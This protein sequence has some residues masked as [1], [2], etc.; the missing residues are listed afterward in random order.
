MSRGQRNRILASR[1][2]VLI[3]L[4][5]AIF[6]IMVVTTT[7]EGDAAP[8]LYLETADIVPET[9]QP[10]KDS[11]STVDVTVHNGGDSNATGFYVKLRDLTASKDLGTM[12]PYNLTANSSIE[13][14]F[15]WDLTGATGGKHT[16][17]ASA[18]SGSDITESNETDNTA[19]LDVTVNLPPVASAASNLGFANTGLEIGFSAAGSSDPDGIISNYLWYFGDGDTEEG[20]NVSHAYTDG[21]P[22]PGKT[23][24]ITLV[25][26]DEDGGLASKTI[27][28]RIY[29][30]LPT[31]IA[32]DVTIVTMTPTSI[33]GA[34]STD[35]DGKVTK[36]RWTLHN[37]TVLWGSTIV[38]SY[39][40]DGWYRIDLLV[41][42]DD[43][44]SDD[45]YINVTV[46]NQ[47]PSIDLRANRTLVSKGD[48]IRFD[49]S[50]SEDVDGTIT[51]YTWIFGDST[52][53]T[54]SV[55]DHS[56]SE[57]G[58]YNI[59]LVLVD[60]DGAISYS[61]IRVIVG[62][63]AP[64]AVA[65]ASIGYVL[66]YEDVEFNASSSS[67]VDDNMAT[68]AWDF[69]D[70]FSTMGKL[71]VHNFTDDGTYV[72]TL[73]L[74]DTAGAFATSTVTIVVGNRAPVAIFNDLTVMTH[75]PVW[76]NGSMCQDKDGYIASYLW[77][78]GEGLVYSTANASH[79]W[80]SPGIYTVLLSIWDDD[81]TKN[82]TTFD[83]TVLNQ[84]PIAVMVAD[85]VETTLA[86]PVYFNGTGSR[87][88]DGEITNWTWTF[89]DG[90][91][92]YGEEVNHTYST[93]GTYFA[94]LTVRDTSGGI[95][96]TGL[97]ISVRNQPPLVSVYINPLVTYTGDI[98]I[99][100]GSNSSD[101]ENQIAEYYW[102]FGDGE[103]ATG[104]IVTH[105]YQDDS[106]YTARLT[107]IDQD[108]TTSF[109]EVI[110][111]V[112][113]R[114]PIPKA[115]A[116][117]ATAKTL[118]SMTFKGTMSEDPDGRVLW[119]HWDFGDGATGFGDIVD[120]AYSDDGTYTVTLT[121]TDDDGAEASHSV[122]VEVTNRA[123]FAMAG[124]GQTTQT[125]IPVRLD[126]RQSYDLDGDVVK[127]LWDFGDETT[128]T[129]PVV[130][131]SF[132]T[133][134]TFL[135]EL[136]VTDDD[137]DTSTS[138]LTVIVQN[139]QPVAKFTGNTRIL[140]GQT[141]E[142]DGSDSYDLDGLIA[143]ADYKWDM[144]DGTS[145]VGILVQYQ[146]DSVGTY[147]VILTV[148]DDG[149]LTST[150]TRMVEVL[151]RMPSAQISASQRVLS[152]GDSL[153]LDGSGS[154][155]PDG[156][157]KD[158]TWI[159]GDGSVAYGRQVSYIYGDDGIYMVVLTV[160]DDL[161]GTDSTSVFIQ[162]EN[163]PPMPAI[164]GPDTVQTL[165]SVEFTAE[166]TLD[167]D[168]RVEGHFWDFGDGNSG[169][170]WNVSHEYITSGIYTVSLIVLDDDGRSAI[171]NVSI[172][173][174]N[175]PPIV[176]AEAPL[177]ATQ[178]TTVNFNATRSYDPDG[179]ITEWQWDFG[180]DRTGEGRDTYHRYIEV[181]T[182][183]WVLTVVDDSGAIKEVSGSI[184]IKDPPFD[185]GGGPGP[186]NGDNTDESPGPGAIVAVA[187]LTLA[188]I[189]ITVRRKRQQA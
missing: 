3:L 126:G 155:D 61:T 68:Y 122:Q 7:Q 42:D 23:Y 71:V 20:Y 72:V 34:S 63:T 14:G 84:A 88:M 104:P 16:L 119:F 100:N 62:N 82:H 185:P 87:D 56:F 141:L 154:M 48:S 50:G 89:G 32:S 179:L 15:T 44:E 43:G 77:D 147:T 151:N 142:L 103:S 188:G 55:V 171:T 30:R 115:E 38:V 70:G 101:P 11:T 90:A 189:S 182:Y 169:N 12:G 22:S 175:R 10:T 158:F 33:S 166:G 69:G 139:V 94:T 145:K 168:G 153:D 137:G 64:L 105:V 92:G 102:S 106:W 65:R 120:H 1:V 45:T 52:T 167:P 114:L 35:A 170:G 143:K 67:D 159:Y 19:T 21:E 83:V 146:Y 131:H 129:G 78:L 13:I 37:D 123:P 135:V 98:V 173:V 124:N 76:F 118:D 176:E 128:A 57:N 51:N 66:T 140:S 9:T 74:T 97:L 157:V 132:P 161:G 184:Y 28:V 93:Y 160:T 54:S 81:G 165:T 177:E 144:G 164:V 60:D 80:D 107:V 95:N 183:T 59:T 26:T 39:P 86:R 148:E 117:P 6:L 130:T 49:A 162:V 29:N 36:F 47:A 109:L 181:G 149:G 152:T 150:Y 163:R 18:D 24:N 58:S 46:L 99:F 108:A 111:K 17:K 174:I 134:G 187:T 79:S 121:V 73:T 116:T 40:D 112:M 8:N 138:N 180:D 4:T 133:Y 25:I 113:N 156:S 53:A 127:Y 31:A 186:N 125:G 96:T 110:V 75:E 136:M 91:K 27:T 41:W 172:V 85:P 5:L 178:N 2:M